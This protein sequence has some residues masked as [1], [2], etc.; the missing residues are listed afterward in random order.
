MS[1]P[2]GKFMSQQMRQIKTEDSTKELERDISV[3]RQARGTGGLHGSWVGQQQP[4]EERRVFR[5]ERIKDEEGKAA[6]A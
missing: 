6:G 3:V 2:Q 1:L 4:E 5:T